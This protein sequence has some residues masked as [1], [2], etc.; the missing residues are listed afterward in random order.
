MV[1]MSFK[2]TLRSTL[3]RDGFRPK[4]SPRIT[5]IETSTYPTPDEYNNLTELYLIMVNEKNAMQK[6]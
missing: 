4:R 3:E 1:E 2:E 5:G 6:Q